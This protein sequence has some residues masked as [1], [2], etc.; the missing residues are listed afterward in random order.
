M[1]RTV[2]SLVNCAWS[3]DEAHEGCVVPGVGHSVCS[4]NLRDTSEPHMTFVVHSLRLYV[5]ELTAKLYTALLI[6]L[7]QFLH[8]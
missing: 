5:Q 3:V 7:T 4:H 8:S 2:L 1:P 6:L